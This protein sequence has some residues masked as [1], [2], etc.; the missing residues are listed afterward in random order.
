MRST[1]LTATLLDLFK[2]GVAA[3]IL[4][5]AGEACFAQA[6]VNLTA[7]ASTA[8][9]PDG[10]AV[11][12]WGYSCTPAAVATV[13]AANATC[14]AANPAAGAN[15]SPVVV[16]VPA[17]QLQINLTNN[18]PAPVPTSLVIVGQLG[19]GL[20]DKPTTTPSPV[21]P[22]QTATS[23]PTVTA[24]STAPMA[25][26]VPP[27]QGPRVQSFG[28]EVAPSTD[29]KSHTTLTWTNL[30]P[31]TYLLESG[32]HPSIQGPMGLYGVLVVKSPSVPSSTCASTKQAYPNSVSCYDAD[33]PLVMSEIDPVQNA[34]V[35]A[36]VATKGFS[37]TAAWSGQ[38]GG[39]GDSKS[40]TFGTCYPPV[41]NYDP[42][43]YLINGV[44]FDRTNP[45]ASAFPPSATVPPST[46]QVLVRLVNAGLR[47]HVPAVVGAQ[48]GNP[49]VPGFTLIAEDG[50]VI[51]GA[52]RIQNAV[53]MAAGKTYD[54]ML[55][56]PAAGAMPVY[57]RQLSLSTNNMRDGGMQGYI[58][59]NNAQPSAT[60]GIGETPTAAGANYYFVPGTTLSVSDPAKGVIANDSGVYGVKVQTPP[61]SGTLTLNTD[62][63]FT[64]LSSSTANDSFV[65]QS[66]NGTPPVTDR[67]SVV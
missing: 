12:M 33:V 40:V 35:A 37:E 52:A 29:P 49:S 23:W 67:K 32:T 10:Q 11:P 22:T 45:N 53:F 56:A 47:M 2:A 61:A 15:W 48:T 34:A 54:L 25:S 19:G 41:V 21:H 6:V 8:M 59:V 58:A 42:R 51:P 28:T 43:Y 18:L 17:G 16:T 66:T 26:F 57:D 60:A 31:G 64:Y 46:G 65:Y 5:T 55:N 27:A 24:T 3:S 13:P 38:P 39:C 44:A 14:A 9:M 1:K 4:L 62:G 63:T 30:K 20:G 50:N 36:A 7:K